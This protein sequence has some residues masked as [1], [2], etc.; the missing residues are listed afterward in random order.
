MFSGSSLEC[1]PERWVALVEQLLK[2]YVLPAPVS[3][4]A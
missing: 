3:R 4:V 2:V 1:L